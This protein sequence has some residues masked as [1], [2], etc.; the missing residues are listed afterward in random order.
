MRSVTKVAHTSDDSLAIPPRQQFL[1]LVF[2]EPREADLLG[3]VQRIAGWRPVLLVGEGSHRTKEFFELQRDITLQAIRGGCRDVF[4]EVP[5]F[6]V[7]ELNQIMA[8]NEPGAISG[9]IKKNFFLTWSGTPIVEL[10]QGIAE[11]N[12][13]KGLSE[14]SVRVHGID[15]QARG[16]VSHLESLQEKHRGSTIANDLNKLMASWKD[17][18]TNEQQY[19]EALRRQNRTEQAT[20]LLV[21]RRIRSECLG[22]VRDLQ[23]GEGISVA[24]Q[25]VLQAISTHLEVM[26]QPIRVG[27]RKRDEHMAK[28]IVEAVPDLP[29]DRAGAPL[30]VVLAHNSHVSVGP[31][32]KAG[33]WFSLGTGTHVRKALMNRAGWTGVNPC[34]VVCQASKS[35]TLAPFRNEKNEYAHESMIRGELQGTHSEINA[36]CAVLSFFP[37]SE[38]SVSPH[39]SSYGATGILQYGS[40][41]PEESRKWVSSIRLPEHMDILVF[42]SSTHGT[43]WV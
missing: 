42:Y 32:G 27:V 3:Q 34:T 12:F 29:T 26:A 9:F 21:I 35:G 37:A 5:N 1:P 41:D 20:A 39:A 38:S 43:D 14:G 15:P 22:L 8:R 25:Q 28:R 10:L 31:I 33:G 7:S 17:Y 19:Y 11:F 6:L 2:K 16:I 30:A 36:D 23:K 13:K 24:D 40:N 18:S 4:L